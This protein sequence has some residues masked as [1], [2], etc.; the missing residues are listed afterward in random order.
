LHFQISKY[1]AANIYGQTAPM[2]FLVKDINDVVLERYLPIE[3][4]RLTAIAN[5]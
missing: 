5:P 3:G 4:N 1:S 2:R